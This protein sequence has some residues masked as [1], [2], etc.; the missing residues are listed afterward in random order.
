VQFLYQEIISLNLNLVI[1]N[2]LY[3]SIVNDCACEVISGMFGCFGVLLC[4]VVGTGNIFETT[5][6]SA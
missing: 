3:H 2:L 4:S 6:V 1:K 5:N